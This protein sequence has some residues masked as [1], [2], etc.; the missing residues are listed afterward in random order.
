MP[1]IGDNELHTRLSYKF[2]MHPKTV[3]WIIINKD[4]LTG[5]NGQFGINIPV[6]AVRLIY[7]QVVPLSRFRI[8]S[9]SVACET[10]IPGR[11]YYSF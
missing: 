6:N 10:R 3:I 4:T 11:F 2:F 5:T 1:V 7:K 8:L 9:I